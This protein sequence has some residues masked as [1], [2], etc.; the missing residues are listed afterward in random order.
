MFGK[1]MD[2]LQ[3]NNKGIYVLFDSTLKW[4]RH[5]THPDLEVMSRMNTMTLG[6]VSGAI[7]GCLQA[8]GLDT[9]TSETVE[10]AFYKFTIRINEPKTSP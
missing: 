5:A 2:R 3:T 8:L 6:I 7:K 4:V 9:K 10:G 1:I